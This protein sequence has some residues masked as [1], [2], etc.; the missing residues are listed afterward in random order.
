[1]PPLDCQ[2]GAYG[3]TKDLETKYLF[4]SFVPDIKKH[5]SDLSNNSFFRTF[6]P[7]MLIH[8]NHLKQ[9]KIKKIFCCYNCLDFHHTQNFFILF[10]VFPV[11][12]S[13]VWKRSKF[14]GLWPGTWTSFLNTVF[15]LSITGKTS[16]SHLD[17]LFSQ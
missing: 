6:S 5:Y 3:L 11:I 10:V 15:L 12:S 13:S 8:I 9:G 17:Q 14:L 7:P 4:A 2:N 1:M 16:N